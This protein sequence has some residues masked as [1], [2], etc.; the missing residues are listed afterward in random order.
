MNTVPG[1]SS[2]S[3]STRLMWVL[4]A[5]ALAASVAV[6][7]V[8][9]IVGF[10][11]SGPGDQ[12]VFPIRWTAATPEKGVPW[13]KSTIELRE[14][15]SARVAD[16]LVGEIGEGDAG[17]RCVAA[18]PTTFSGTGRWAMDADGHLRIDTDAGVALFA[19]WPGRFDGVDWGSIH[20]ELCDGA[21]ADF[22]ART[23]SR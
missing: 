16:L 19:P 9:V 3:M 1:D 15:G 18:D 5:I 7:A 2:L 21:P 4:V 6:I 11:R 12:L 20:E 22:A 13:E 23:P 14:D 17:D 8:I 10:T